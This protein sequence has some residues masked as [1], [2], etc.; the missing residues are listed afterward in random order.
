[1][2]GKE[3]PQAKQSLSVAAIKVKWDWLQAKVEVEVGLE[4]GIDGER[5]PPNRRL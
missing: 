1:M 3:W 5:R 2:A 4:A